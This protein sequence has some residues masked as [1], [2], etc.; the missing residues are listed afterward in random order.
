MAYRT[1]ILAG[2]IAYATIPT[3][4][5][6]ADWWWPA[7]GKLHAPWCDHESMTMREAEVCRAIARAQALAT[8]RREDAQNLAAARE[9]EAA[10]LAARPPCEP[11]NAYQTY[12]AEKARRQGR[13]PEC[14]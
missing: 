12:L 1:L 11:G 14:K 7:L 3:T 13:V 10:R 2:L 8:A 6:Q 9:H 5:A 4:A